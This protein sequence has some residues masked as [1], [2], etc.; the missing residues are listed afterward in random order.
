MSIR[1]S[2]IVI[3]G[4]S[5]TEGFGLSFTEA[6]PFLL[7]VYLGEEY[8][9]INCGVTSSCVINTRY[10]E[11]TVGLPYKQTSKYLKALEEK[12]DLYIINLGTNDAQDGLIEETGV[13]D[14]YSNLIHFV[15]EFE[16]SYEAM[17]HDIYT[18]NPYA[19][20]MMCLPIPILNCIWPK[21]QQKYLEVII[22]KLKRIAKKH[23][24]EL[25]DLK[26]PLINQLHN[27]YQEDGL[28]L[29]ALGHMTI[30]NYLFHKI[31][32]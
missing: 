15:S 7:N 24:L 17:I 29:N 13:K 23:D 26:I 12:G 21:H 6:Y 14:I 18:C 27:Y 4:D 1:K 22:E 32:K 9:V 25:C 31:R 19:E 10:K 5:N 16:A 20:I 28:H 2:K 8:Q 11:R 30:A 3:L